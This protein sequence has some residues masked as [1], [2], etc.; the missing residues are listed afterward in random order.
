M[1]LLDM[2]DNLGITKI[3]SALEKIALEFSFFRISYDSENTRKRISETFNTPSFV[4]EIEKNEPKVQ[5]NIDDWRDYLHK[6][7]LVLISIGGFFITM[8]TISQ[9]NIDLGKIA[10]G[11]AW[12][13]ISIAMTF[14][15]IFLT[16][17][18]QR[19]IL[20][21]NF[22]FGQWCGAPYDKHPDE[23]HWADAVR[24]NLKELIEKN[25]E[26]L[27]TET[28][29]KKERRNLKKAIKE[30]TKQ[31]K[32]MKYCGGTYSWLEQVR[33]WLTTII[34][35]T[36]FVGIFILG[37]SVIQ[38]Q[39]TE[40]GKQ[41]EVIEYIKNFVPIEKQEEFNKMD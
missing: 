12:L 31:L 16:I 34:I 39:K 8:V 35:I 30:D 27:K 6:Y 20:D 25:K 22:A 14:L 13:G 19:K 1:N 38:T 5:K 15:T 29:N 40:T 32:S 24:R 2:L 41:F 26:K 7:S 37:S 33:V 11:F 28:L 21:G 4:K 3:G 18:L 17:F 10:Y 23:I 36:S 9:K